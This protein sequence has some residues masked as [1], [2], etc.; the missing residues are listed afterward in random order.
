MGRSRTYLLAHRNQEVDSEHIGVFNDL[1]DR[2]RRG[3]PIAYLVGSKEFWS[4]D[5]VVNEQV[6]IPRPDTETLVECAL[7]HCSSQSLNIAD[8]GTGSG[9]IAL[10]IARELPHCSVM[11]VDNSRQAL[12]I[13]QSNVTRLGARNVE[14][15]HS[16][17]FDGLE[18]LAFDLVVSNP[19]YID[20]SD[21]HLLGEVRYEPRC[22][23]VSGDN[24]FADLSTVI[25]AAPGYIKSEGWLMVEHGY[26][27]AQTVTGLFLSTGFTNVR[28]YRDLAGNER[29][30]EG[31][32]TEW[33]KPG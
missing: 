1:L 5:L 26:L 30:T 15:R 21:T 13:A 3:V 19:P 10:A 12:E 29:V 23:L 2:R 11:A 25:V 16:N 27:Q 31:Q 9:A 32:W 6:L 20:C 22:A 33:S 18:G 7:R 24:G 8:L 28:T 14:V 17:W 4:I